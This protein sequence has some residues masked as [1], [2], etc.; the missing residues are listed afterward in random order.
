[1]D[2][3]RERA[4]A[5]LF[6]RYAYPPNDLGH[7]DVDHARELVACAAGEIAVSALGAL[8][9]GYQA[10]IPS[11]ALIAHAAGIADPFDARVVEAYWVGNALLDDPS[12]PMPPPHHNFRVLG[13]S[14]WVSMVRAHESDSALDVLEKCRVRWGRVLAIR[15]GVAAVRSRPLVQHGRTIELGEA[16]IELAAL[17]F[18]GEGTQP[19]VRRGDWC[20][21]HWDWVC[22]RLSTRQLV[23]LRRVTRMQLDAI[24]DAPD[25]VLAEV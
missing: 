24:N 17:K 21:L 13:A 14:P 4:G 2:A 8:A 23:Q 3:T 1:M 5:L 7:S 15:D 6:S 25:G 22:D 12:L 10:A 19:R 18:E 16:R 20:A 11:L 9:R